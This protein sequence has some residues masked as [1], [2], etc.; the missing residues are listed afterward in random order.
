MS[1]PTVK[2]TAPG[3][4]A[5]MPMAIDGSLRVGIKVLKF[6]KRNLSI[7]QEQR[8]QLE[9]VELRASA[10]PGWSSMACRSNG[11]R[12]FALGAILVL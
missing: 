8:L 10:P 6:V 5:T 1:R 2:G 7:I 4:R 9:P 3:T 11:G 12:L